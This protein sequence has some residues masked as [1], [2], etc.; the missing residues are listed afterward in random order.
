[1]SLHE[2][3]GIPAPPPPQLPPL[4]PLAARKAKARFWS[5]LADFAELGQDAKPWRSLAD[6]GHPFLVRSGEGVR[7]VPPP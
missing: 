5:L 1:M 7:V 3:W 2:A 6:A 4:A